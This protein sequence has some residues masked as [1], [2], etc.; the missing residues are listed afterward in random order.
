MNKISVVIPSYN[1][2]LTI[3][4]TIDALLGQEKELLE[5]II[6]VDSSDDQ[7]TRDLLSCYDNPKLKT[8]LLPKKTV[9]AIGR[10]IGAEKARA[11]VIAFIDSDAYPADDWLNKISEAADEGVLVGGGSIALPTF[12]RWSLIAGAQYLLQFNEFIDHGEKRQKSFVPSCNLFCEKA[13]FQSIGGFPDIRAS[14]D[15]L[16]G[17]K[18]GE[19][20]KLYFIPDIK[21]YHIFR[22]E[23]GGYLRNQE[24]LGRYIL[25]YR[26]QRSDSWIYKGLAAAAFLPAFL[27]I[28]FLR[29][30][31]RVLTSF[32]MELYTLFVVSLPLFL[33][34]LCSWA[35]GFFQGSISKEEP[36]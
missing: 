24:L 34:G 25:I 10:N 4:Y 21:V 14:E 22:K 27:V 18:A 5:E 30:S 35:W 33:L 9:P 12:Q 29:I 3:R 26:R 13:L 32:N 23:F 17:F 7:K 16:F 31:Q 1:S 11:R 28:K 19:K 2:F 36:V 6:V 8:I 20:T 15:V